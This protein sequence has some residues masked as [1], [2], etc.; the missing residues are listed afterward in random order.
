V[1]FLMLVKATGACHIRGPDDIPY[2][3]ENCY[4]HTFILVLVSLWMPIG[5]VLLTH[6]HLKHSREN[7][8]WH[9]RPH[10]SQEGSYFAGCSLVN[11]RNTHV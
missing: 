5:V 11:A 3:K 6:H 4:K 9:G 10:Y 2:V 1:F 8:Y 7:G